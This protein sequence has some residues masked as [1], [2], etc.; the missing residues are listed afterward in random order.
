MID[1]PGDG[2]PL[3]ETPQPVTSPTT[4]IAA[5]AFPTTRACFFLAVRMPLLLGV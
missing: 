4:A 5:T 1:T 3:S 2:S